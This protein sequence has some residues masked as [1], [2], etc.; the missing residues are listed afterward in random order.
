MGV[1]ALELSKTSC[2]K[3]YARRP[4]SNVRWLNDID[5]AAFRVSAVFWGFAATR[6]LKM[7]RRLAPAKLP[8]E[9]EKAIDLA[10]ARRQD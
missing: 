10:T 2:K 9:S 8:V 1:L 6:V 4:K 7:S 5:D 3:S